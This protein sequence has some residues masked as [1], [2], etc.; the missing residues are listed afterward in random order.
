MLLILN[1]YYIAEL[2]KQVWLRLNTVLPRCLWV[3]SINALLYESTAVKNV[4]LTQENIVLDPLQV[5]RCDHQV[6]RLVSPFIIAGYEC[7]ETLF[8]VCNTFSQYNESGQPCQ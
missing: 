1:V 4:F 5:L 2:Y 7:N 3:I 6:F 8:G